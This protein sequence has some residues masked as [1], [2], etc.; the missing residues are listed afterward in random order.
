MPI[1][2]TARLGLTRWSDDNDEW[3]R[4]DFDGNS[5]ALEAL[6]AIDVQVANFAALPAAGIEGRY[7][8][9]EDTQ[10]VFRDN[11]AAWKAIAPGVLIDKRQRSTG[12]AGVTVTDGMGGASAGYGSLSLPCPTYI[13][14]GVQPVLN[15]TAAV[16]GITVNVPGVYLWTVQLVMLRNGGSAVNVETLLRRNSAGTRTGGTQEYHVAFH[17]SAVDNI[18]HHHTASWPVVITAAEVPDE[19]HVV[20][21]MNTTGANPVVIGDGTAWTLTKLGDLAA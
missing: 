6:A 21:T 19:F 2:T 14:S 5:A 7:G 9:C 13:Q 12:G 18:Y 15:A 4:E 1:T 16:D 3:S 11:G 20:A 17:M 8:Y 10:K